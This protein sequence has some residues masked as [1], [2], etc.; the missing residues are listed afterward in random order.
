MSIIVNIWEFL[1]LIQEKITSL[2]PG[3]PVYAW[4][5]SDELQWKACYFYQVSQW[6]KIADDSTW[7]HKKESL[8]EFV[9]ISWQK[10]TPD[11]ELYEMLSSIVNKILLEEGAAWELPGGF[12][13]WSIREWSQSGVF[14]DV[15]ERPYIIAQFF[16]IYQA[17]YDSLPRL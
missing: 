6:P 16:F 15:K 3:F 12:K 5:P 13:I 7:V 8:M 4:K 17:R 11:V 9:V 1:D 14:H 10:N 2:N